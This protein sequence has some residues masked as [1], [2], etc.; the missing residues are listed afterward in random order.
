MLDID[1]MWSS[2]DSTFA[3]NTWFDS[4]FPGSDV[5]QASR[6]NMVCEECLA[7]DMPELQYFQQNWNSADPTEVLRS[8]S[9]VMGFNKDPKSIFDADKIGQVWLHAPFVLSSSKS[10]DVFVSD[11]A[12][13]LTQ[14]CVF[15]VHLRDLFGSRAESAPTAF[16][17]R[18]FLVHRHRCMYRY[19]CCRLCESIKAYSIA[20][21]RCFDIP[22]SVL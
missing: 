5:I 6:V 9:R 8:F 10:V 18:H 21:C 22:D 11:A 19:Q 17:R 12:A 16:N 3:V 4:C 1:E 20:F 15:V 13:D 14:E 7:Y 2:M